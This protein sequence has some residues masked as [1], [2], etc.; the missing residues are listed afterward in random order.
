[1]ERVRL[2]LTT[3]A[4][5]GHCSTIELPFLNKWGG[6]DLNRQP[7][8]YENAALTIELPPLK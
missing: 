4:L 3:N 5:K 7:T 1:M 6:T 2:E 8:L